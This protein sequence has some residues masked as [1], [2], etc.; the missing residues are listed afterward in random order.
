MLSLPPSL[1]HSFLHP[2]NFR[3][4]FVRVHCACDTVLT[5]RRGGGQQRVFNSIFE[6]VFMLTTHSP[7]GGPA[8]GPAIPSFAAHFFL[9]RQAPPP[10]P[11]RCIPS[12]YAPPPLRPSVRPWVFEHRGR[13]GRT[14]AAARAEAGQSPPPPPPSV[15]ADR[16]RPS[17]RAMSDQNTPRLRSMA[18]SRQQTMQQPLDSI[19]SHPARRTNRPLF[20]ILKACGCGVGVFWNA[21]GAQRI[22][23]AKEKATRGQGTVHNDD[24]GTKLKSEPVDTFSRSPSA[25]ASLEGARY[26]LPRNGS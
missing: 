7:P 16:D 4:G 9:F 24:C 22:H 26:Y 11:P 15:G 21:A 6:I 2:Q 19:A 13:R 12:A 3:I 23:F 14:M 5:L 20:P 18:Q 17:V 1:H 8:A 10:P 25:V